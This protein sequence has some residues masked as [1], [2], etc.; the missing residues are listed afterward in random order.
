LLLLLLLLV[1]L[2]LLCKVGLLQRQL[3]V[4]RAVAAAICEQ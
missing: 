1:V 4:A 3:A 2:L